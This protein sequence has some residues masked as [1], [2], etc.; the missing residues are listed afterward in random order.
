V[1]HVAARIGIPILG[2]ALLVRGCVEDRGVTRSLELGTD[3]RLR[4]VSAPES[5]NGTVHSCDRRKPRA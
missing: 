5:R 1:V 2:V 4:V 3:A